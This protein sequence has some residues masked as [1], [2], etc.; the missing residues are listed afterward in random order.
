MLEFVLGK[1][2]LGL[3]LAPQGVPVPAAVAEDVDGTGA[4]LLHERRHMDRG[5]PFPVREEQVCE[6][7]RGVGSAH[8]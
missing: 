8:G 1:E 5:L 2:D 3:L 7:P 4:L 6:T